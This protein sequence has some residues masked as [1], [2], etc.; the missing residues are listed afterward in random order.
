MHLRQC[1]EA[2]LGY[3]LHGYLQK[4]YMTFYVILR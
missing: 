4:A 3:R 1:L 2:L